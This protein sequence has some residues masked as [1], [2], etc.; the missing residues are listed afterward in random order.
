MN[1]DSGAILQ[2]IKDSMKK[3]VLCIKMESTSF[4]K[5][6]IQVEK[7]IVVPGFSTLLTWILKYLLVASSIDCYVYKAEL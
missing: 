5:V 1:T 3:D 7:H 6:L 4:I 2:V